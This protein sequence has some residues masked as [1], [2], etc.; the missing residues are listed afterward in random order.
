MGKEL[1]VQAIESMPFAENTYIAHLAG[2][3]DCVVIDPGLE[4]DLILSYLADAGLTPV[5]ILNTHGH[6]DHI[7]GNAAL[8]QAF[9]NVPLLIGAGDAQML[10][11]PWENLSAMFGTPI[12]SPP[13]DRLLLEDDV[14]ELAGQRWLILEISGHSPGHIV[15]RD[16]DRPVV[17]GGDV[18]FAGSVGRT[19][20]PG[21]SFEK[22]AE[23]IQAKLFTL[24]DDVVIYP[25]HGPATTVGRE[26]RTNP[27]VGLAAR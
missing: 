18:L 23:G 14:V 16:L 26:K 21:G 20:F 27:F 6:A 4:P 19:D 3:T 7:G 1:Q 15:F 25:G 9:P 24:P 12:T 2:R 10:T 13:A 17:F 11:D 22:L 5:A 8:K